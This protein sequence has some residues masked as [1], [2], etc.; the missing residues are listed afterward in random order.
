MLTDASVADLRVKSV[1]VGGWGGGGG[2][3]R[4]ESKHRGANG[5]SILRAF[6]WRAIIVKRI[7]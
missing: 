7:S 5:V 1:V 2:G 4:M 3:G 6:K